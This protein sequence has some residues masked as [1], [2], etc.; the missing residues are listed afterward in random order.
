MAYLLFSQSHLL[1]YSN[2]PAPSMDVVMEGDPDQD[3][4]RIV[5]EP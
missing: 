5:D 1:Q 2:P 4:A 3:V